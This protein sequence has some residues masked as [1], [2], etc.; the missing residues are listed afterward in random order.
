MSKKLDKPDC[1]EIETCPKNA[2]SAEE[3]C[4]F[5]W[6]ARI[7]RVRDKFLEVGMKLEKI[8]D[9]GKTPCGCGRQNV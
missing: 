5:C 6:N 3:V 2:M 7:S 4:N 9:C 1:Q 8:C